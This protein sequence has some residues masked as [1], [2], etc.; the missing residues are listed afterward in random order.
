MALEL[1]IKFKEKNWLKNNVKEIK[2]RIRK[3]PTYVGCSSER[4]WLRKGSL[5]ERGKKDISHDVMFL[6]EK[7]FIFVEIVSDSREIATDLK[8][9]FDFLE[10]TRLVVIEDEDGESPQWYF[11]GA[12]K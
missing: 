7:E 1:Y 11:N 4:L 10:S 12:I 2:D 9:I 8:S 6:F 5:E 3:L